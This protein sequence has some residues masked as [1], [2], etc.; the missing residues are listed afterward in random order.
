MGGHWLPLRSKHR[1]TLRIAGGLRWIRLRVALDLRSRFP[2]DRFESNF[3]PLRALLDVGITVR[4]REE[5]ELFVDARNLLDQRA[6]V[7]ALQFPLPGISLF[8]GMR[9]RL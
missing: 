3:G 8:G 1:L 7:D 6:T 9:V 2:F 4:P 5:L